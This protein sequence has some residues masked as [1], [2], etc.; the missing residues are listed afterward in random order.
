MKI[1]NFKKTAAGIMSV[2]MMLS[3]T[4]LPGTVENLPAI[5]NVLTASAADGETSG[6]DP[7][8]PEV[9]TSFPVTPGGYVEIDCDKDGQYD[10]KLYDYGAGI[11]TKIVVDNAASVFY[12]LSENVIQYIEAAGLNGKLNAPVTV[13]I[14]RATGKVIVNDNSLSNW[15]T[16]DNVIIGSGTQLLA[17]SFGSTKIKNLTIE[18]STIPFAYDCFNSENLSELESFKFD[19]TAEEYEAFKDVNPSVIARITSLKPED[20]DWDVPG[21]GISGD[22]EN[23]PDGVSINMNLKFGKTVGGSFFIENDS[24]EVVRFTLSQDDSSAGSGHQNINVPTIIDSHSK[25]KVDFYVSPKNMATKI[26]YTIEV[27]E[28]GEYKFFK[29]SYISVERYLN[30]VLGMWD[31]PQAKEYQNF[32]KASLVYG[33]TAQ[34]YF[35]QVGQK[36]SGPAFEYPIPSYT[37]SAEGKDFNREGETPISKLQGMN[38]TNWGAGKFFDTTQVKDYIGISMVL[39]SETYFRVHNKKSNN[40]NSYFQSDLIPAYFLN[41][42]YVGTGSTGE[43]FNY[44]PMMWINAALAKNDINNITYQMGVALKQFAWEAYIL[45]CKGLVSHIY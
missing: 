31:E 20:C 3:A 7:V 42:D 8:A 39:E 36:I 1:V 30:M 12:S 28:N 35:S 13:E 34:K 22:D 44:S 15:G 40:T 19:G 25:Q 5:S 27:T 37:I 43:T 4:V 21:E 29:S 45:D 24:D 17:N 2:A 14:R 6:G 41:K 26:R 18:P 23:L 38:F 11:G 33:Y 16:I 9:G 32:I 10:A